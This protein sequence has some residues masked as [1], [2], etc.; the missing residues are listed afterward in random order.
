MLTLYDPT[1]FYPS[2]FL[3]IILF[4]HLFYP[5]KSIRTNKKFWPKI[6]FWTLIFFCKIN[7]CTNFFFT[8]KKFLDP[9]I[10]WTKKIFNPKIIFTIYLRPVYGWVYSIS[11]IDWSSKLPIYR[12]VIFLS[13]RVVYGSKALNKTYFTNDPIF[14]SFVLK[15]SSTR[16]LGYKAKAREGPRKAP[17]GGS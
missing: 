1:F 15:L 14:R 13:I 9:E 6:L 12:G 17:K 8:L 16:I 4:V 11:T 2:I 10:I 5:L 3:P 7:F